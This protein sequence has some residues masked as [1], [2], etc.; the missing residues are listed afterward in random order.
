M[1][2]RRWTKGPLWLL[3]LLPAGIL[4]AV[5]GHAWQVREIYV[6]GATLFS[7]EAVR[8][9]LA[10]A[11]GR[12]PLRASASTL[13]EKVLALPWVADAHIT[14]EL[15][16]TV[17]CI[18]QER[19]P[20][21]FLADQNPPLLVDQQ[22]RLLGP[23]QE[24]KDLLQLVDFG[25]YP[26]DRAQVLAL[27]PRLGELWGKPP[28]RCQRLAAR[29]LAVTF[30]GESLV[31][32]LDPQKPELLATGKQVLAAWRQQ[33]GPP[34]ARLDVRVPGRVFLQPQEVPR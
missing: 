24:P 11:V 12:S 6:S 5:L 23:S 20:A 3:F 9:V 19:K 2:A 34:V 13:R 26:E 21:A 33:G 28:V 25:P 29:D 10:Q 14:L 7:Q 22:G 16:G 27:L 30:A 31:V 32:L 4:A 18:V 1:R 17:R 15:S 8:Q